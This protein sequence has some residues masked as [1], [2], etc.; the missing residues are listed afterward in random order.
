MAE[1]ENQIS[2]E[3]KQA[4][5]KK[6]AVSTR[7]LRSIKAAFMQAKTEK[8]AGGEISDEKAL[9]I[10]Q[11]MLKQRQ[12][13]ISV[14]TEQNRMD[15][16]EK[17]QEEAEVISKFLPEPLTEEELKAAVDEIIAEL[18]A[19]S[20]KDMGAVMKEANIR[21]KGKADGKALADVVK[22]SLNA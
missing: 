11:K 3:L 21:L 1:L 7:A 9:A 2:Q 18:G 12:E 5:L 19:S 16:A 6:D 13:S 8:G 17:E 22:N 4:M 15:L 10:L 20:M 14:F